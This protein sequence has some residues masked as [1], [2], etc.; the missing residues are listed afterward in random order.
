MKLIIDKTYTGALFVIC[1]FYF[2]GISLYTLLPE[3][4]D[5]IPYDSAWWK[6]SYFINN[7]IFFFS[8]PF[9]ASFLSYDPGVKILL[10]GTSFFLLSL[11]LFQIFKVLG[12]DISKLIWVS[13]CPIYIIFILILCKNGSRKIY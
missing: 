10:R 1:I 2:T 7:G 13:F 3:I 9:I 12:F 8:L 4:V 5:F 6:V 11:S